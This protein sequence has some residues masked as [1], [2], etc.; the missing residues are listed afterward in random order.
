MN[1]NFKLDI[2]DNFEF[3]GYQICQQ[4]VH[5]I[6][7]FQSH[8]LLKSKNGKAKLVIFSKK[9]IQYLKT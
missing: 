3:L 2:L 9:L 4:T 1:M 8:F 6:T 5:K 7:K